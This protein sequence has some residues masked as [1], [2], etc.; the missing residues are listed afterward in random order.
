MRADVLGA[1]SLTKAEL[2]I[3]PLLSTHLTFRE[4]G[5]RVYITQNTVKKHAMSIYQKLGVASCS[6]AVQRAQELGLGA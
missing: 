5:E 6:Q 4:I 2:R 1:S 3:L